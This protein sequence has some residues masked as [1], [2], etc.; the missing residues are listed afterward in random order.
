MS[1]QWKDVS[2]YSRSDKERKPWAWEIRL[3]V[4]RLVVVY[5]HRDYPGQ[6]IYY[7]PSVIGDTLLPVAHTEEEAKRHALG[8]VHRLTAQII[9]A[10]NEIQ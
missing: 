5:N 1:A 6:Y 4:W 9:E 2:T 10:V 3:G 7:I 8:G